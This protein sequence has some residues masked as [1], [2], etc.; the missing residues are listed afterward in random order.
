IAVRSDPDGDRQA[1]WNK[2]EALRSQGFRVVE[3]A[4]EYLDRDQ[5]LVWNGE[6][7]QILGR[8]KN[9]KA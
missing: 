4:I 1:L 2:I 6:Q 7:W 8:V 5:E 3:G 9:K